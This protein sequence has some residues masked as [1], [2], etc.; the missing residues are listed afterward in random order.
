MRP[1]LKGM[2]RLESLLDHS[3]DLEHIAWANA[4]LDVQQ[5]NERKIE[6]AV[7]DRQR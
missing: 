7:K 4:A 6:Q 2:V 1:V 5:E 3:I